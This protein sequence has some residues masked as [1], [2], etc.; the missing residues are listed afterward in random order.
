MHGIL[1]RELEAETVEFIQ[2]FVG[3]HDPESGDIGTVREVRI[4][5]ERGESVAWLLAAFEQFLAA[6]QDLLDRLS[7]DGA[8]AG[9]IRE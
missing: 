9:A 3:I 4:V 5:T 1:K 8:L 7:V 2:Q 6:R